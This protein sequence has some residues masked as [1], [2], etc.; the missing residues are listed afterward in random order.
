MTHSLVSILIPCHN[1]E[2]F[3]QAT[4]ESALAQSHPRLEIILVDDGSTDDSL[5]IARSYEPRVK[6]FTGPQKGA[7]AARNQATQYASGEWLQYLDADDLLLPHAISSRVAA[8]E[9]TAGDVACSDWLRLTPRPDGLWEPGRL[10]HADYL[11]FGEETDLAVFKGFWAPPAALLYRRTLVQRIGSWH[12]GLP[13]IQ[14][15]RFLFDAAFHGG[16][17]IHVPGESAHYRQHAAYSLSSNSHAQFWADILAN[18]RE[19]EAMW[20]ERGIFKGA[21]RAAVA[22]S[23]RCGAHVTFPFDRGLYR[24]NLAELRRFSEQQWSSYLI[25]ATQ[26]ERLLGYWAARR[27][28]G[29]VRSS[30]LE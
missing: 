26:L 4:L 10:E 18:T 25:A 16:R 21:R 3:L 15:A 8:L 24:A 20:I 9:A 30:I 6:V 5:A 23:Y 1:S 13:I 27:L 19:I 2:A 22:Y 28:L 29:L 11:E 14:D 12:P 7:S 17:F